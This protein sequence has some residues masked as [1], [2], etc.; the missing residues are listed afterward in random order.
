MRQ[1]GG[2][3]KGAAFERL[4]C[5]RLSKWLSGDQRDD[6]FWRSAMSGG[7][8]TIG[9]RL[10]MIRKQQAGDITAVDPLGHALT[11]CYYIEC[12]CY[13]KLDVGSMF[14]SRKGKMHGFWS[15]TLTEADRYG[16]R[17]MLI[18][19]EDRG[20][21]LMVL[22]CGDPLA[23]DNTLASMPGWGSVAL[24]NNVLEREYDANER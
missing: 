11:G 17:P 2:K 1:G 21:I 12:K 13:K 9:A 7:R 3:S 18:A 19:K 5:Q 22:R 16:L 15:T 20:P 4:I 23:K 10:G 14:I 8:A 24:F 6:L